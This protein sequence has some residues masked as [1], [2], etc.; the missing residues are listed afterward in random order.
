MKKFHCATKVI[1]KPQ[2]YHWGLV[3]L[4]MCPSLSLCPLF[5]GSVFPFPGRAG[6]RLSWCC[7]SA[8]SLTALPSGVP[9]KK[10]ALG[11]IAITQGRH[12]QASIS[13][14]TDAPLSQT[15]ERLRDGSRGAVSGLRSWGRAPG[16]APHLSTWPL[17]L[18][19]RD[20]EGQDVKASVSI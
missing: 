2:D 3:D 20:V 5:L 16:G 6:T 4:H 13:W 15:A 14:P 7:V 11:H 18:G 12:A 8:V 19:T 17:S 10:G 9:E 1:L